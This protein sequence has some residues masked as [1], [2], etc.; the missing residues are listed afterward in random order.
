MT[1][2]IILLAIGLVTG[3]ITAMSA[4]SGVMIVVPLLVLLLGFSIHQAI[5]ISLLVDVIASLNVA[6]NYY[7][8]GRVNLRSAAWLAAAAVIG[9]QIGSQLA[10]LIPQD[11]LTGGFSIF[12]ILTGL[13]FWWRAQSK[14]KISLSFLRSRNPKIQA[15]VIAGIGL[16]IGLMTGLFGS[17]GGVTILLV[18]VYILDFPLHMALGTATLIMAITATS[19]VVG[20][21]INGHVPWAEGAVIGLAAML[22]GLF[23]TKVANRISEKAL[24]RVV[25][26]IFILVGIVMVF[27]GNGG[28]DILVRVGIIG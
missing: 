2:I 27:I 12:V 8:Y 15:V 5:G 4:G 10:N 21:S 19:G 16:Y 1:E 3:T 9:A 18:L 20:Y 14:R 28:G 24:N 11:G 22:S 13:L 6:Y 17:G 23:F 26:S 7:R 25:G